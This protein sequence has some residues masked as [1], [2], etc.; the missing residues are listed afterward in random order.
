MMCD[1]HLKS[2]TENSTKIYVK[3]PSLL[4][5][6]SKN[7]PLDVTCVGYDLINKKRAEMYYKWLLFIIIFFVIKL[8]E[9]M[10]M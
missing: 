2:Q 6:C 4:T 7:Q 8:Y 5:S 1:I 3:D 10:N 9:N